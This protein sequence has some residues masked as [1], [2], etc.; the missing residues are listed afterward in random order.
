MKLNQKDWSCPK[1]QQAR[2]DTIIE[3]YQ[4]NFAHSLPSEKQYWTMCGQCSTPDGQPL[5]GCEPTQMIESGFI[6]PE[7]FRGVEINPKIHELNCQAFP[8]LVFFNGDFYR[9]MSNAAFRDKFNPGIVNADFPATPDGGAAYVAKLMAMLTAKSKDILLV[10]NL[11]L[12]MRYYTR[13]DG[14]YLIGLLNEYP[15]FR[16]AWENGNWELCDHY[17]EYNGAGETGSR[18]YMG[19]FIFVRKDDE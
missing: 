8:E 14:D 1:K 6:E 9:E 4:K 13:K 18:I 7:Q 10:V 3:Q 2:L 17:Y 11:I 16:Y 19:S 12:R 15:Q 5:Q